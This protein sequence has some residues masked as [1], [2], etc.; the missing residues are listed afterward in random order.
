MNCESNAENSIE[1]LLKSILGVIESNTTYGV[2][3]M[4]VKVRLGQIKC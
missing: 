3:D 4:V 2:Y 1:K